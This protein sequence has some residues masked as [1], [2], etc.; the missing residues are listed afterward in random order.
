MLELADRVGR[1][2]ENDMT[3]VAPD[4]LGLQ[5]RQLILELGKPFPEAD[6]RRLVQLDAEDAATLINSFL[7][8]FFFA[9]GPPLD[10]AGANALVTD[11]SRVPRGDRPTIPLVYDTLH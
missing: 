5:P 2:I 11:S 4:E 8:G 6:N 7:E 1:R 3:A 10:Q 9:H